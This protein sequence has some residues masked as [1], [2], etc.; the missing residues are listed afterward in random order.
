MSAARTPVPLDPDS[1]KGRAAEAGLAAL[2]TSVRARQA[3]EAAMAESSPVHIVD[4]S[5]VVSA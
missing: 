5:S 4:T 2:V 3:R 1:P